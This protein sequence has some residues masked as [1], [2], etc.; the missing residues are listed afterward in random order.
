M[1]MGFDLAA[2]EAV[3]ACRDSQTASVFS[4]A[5]ASAAA[6]PSVADVYKRQVYVDSEGN[7]S[8]LYLKDLQDPTTGKIPPRLVD[9]KSDKFSSVVETILNA[10]TPADYEAA[11][12]YV[13]NP[14]LLYT[15]R[16]QIT[17][18]TL[19]AFRNST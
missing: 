11:K 2:A 14:C 5:A 3:L 1:A 9:I 4:P 7:V 18:P 10:I 13:P 16:S 8:P 12:Q 19:T 15:S 6:F 17:R